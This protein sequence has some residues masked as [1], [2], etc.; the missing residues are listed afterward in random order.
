MSEDKKVVQEPSVQEPAKEPVDK[1]NEDN[2]SNDHKESD[3]KEALHQSDI[4]KKADYVTREQFD[5]VRGDASA[6]AKQLSALQS[7]LQK[8]RDREAVKDIILDADYPDAIKSKLKGEIDLLT[9]E[10]IKE[11]AD[12]YLDIYQ[13]GVESYKSQ[14]AN[15]INSKPE[16]EAPKDF[17]EKLSSAKSI[18]DLENLMKEAR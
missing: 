6:K 15:A 11:R 3:K 2:Q 7:D 1:V 5:A 18:K 9:P 17:S 13:K 16:R 14:Q 8:L 10:N 12:G 4:S